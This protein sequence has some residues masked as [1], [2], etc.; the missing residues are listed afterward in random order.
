MSK[1]LEELI[2]CHLQN[3]LVV[4]E[5]LALAEELDTSTDARKKIV[6]ETE[7]NSAIIDL[8]SPASKKLQ[9]SDFSQESSRS[10]LKPVSWLV[11]LAACL[12][13]IFNLFRSEKQAVKTSVVHK[14]A[15]AMLV[16]EVGARFEGYR[17]LD[18]IQFNSG[19]FNLTRGTVQ[20]R[21]SSGVDMVIEAPAIFSILDDMRARAFSGKFR[22]VVPPPA[23]GFSVFTDSVIYEDVGTEFAIEVNDKKKSSELHV[24]LGQV[25]VKNKKSAEVINK[26]FQGSAFQYLKNSQALATNFEPEKFTSPTQ[27]GFERWTKQ[28]K[29]QSTDKD[30]IA[31]YTFI[32]KE[33]NY[34]ENHVPGS[35]I[36]NGYIS[37]ARWVTG[38]WPGKKALLFDRDSDYVEIDLPVEIQEMTVSTWL[39]VDRLDTLLSPVFN[40]NNWDPGDIHIQ[41]T[42]DQ[43]PHFDIFGSGV[44]LKKDLLLFEA[45]PVSDWINITA[46][47]SSKENFGIIYINGQ[48]YYKSSFLKNSIIKPGKCRLGSWLPVPG[49]EPKRTFIGRI[50]ELTIWKKT[51]S[52]SEIQKLVEKGRPSV[53]WSRI[54]K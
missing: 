41:L 19:V 1:S 18:E 23:K 13:L 31:N 29:Y 32:Q 26:V 53:E 15:P 47:F 16:N 17:S 24:I 50:D 4:S 40:S 28:V 37:G 45:V 35:K 20:L 3:E 30:I 7:M 48:A 27:V 25:N 10:F 6:S 43:R 9:V 11:A 12:F 2:D 21:F 14:P 22:I 38:R 34:L 44:T 42:K 46:V 39:K 8:L 51:L 36:G 5:K 54:L 52:A 49:F 33:T